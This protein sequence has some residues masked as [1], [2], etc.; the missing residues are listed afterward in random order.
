MSLCCID[1]PTF[2]QHDEKR[3]QHPHLSLSI[4]GLSYLSVLVSLIFFFY[5]LVFQDICKVQ[6]NSREGKREYLH[7]LLHNF[8]D[9][10]CYVAVVKTLFR[11]DR[12][13][14]S[15][16]KVANFDPAGLVPSYGEAR[17]K[18][19]VEKSGKQCLT[20]NFLFRWVMPLAFTKSAYHYDILSFSVVFWMIVFKVYQG[21]QSNSEKCIYHPGTAVFHEGMKYWSCCE[22]KTSDFGAFLEQRGCT[23]GSH[24][25]SKV[26][27]ISCFVRIILV[28]FTSFCSIECFYF[29]L[30]VF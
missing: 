25:W 1:F 28:S 30:S 20:F 5:V 18:V 11:Q 19:L 8:Y 10:G 14:R 26:G 9:I 12:N 4:E 24:C 22:K 6:T 21:E 16:Q 3:T 7:Y 17:F 2:F 29:I 27:F 15:W 23:T 13:P